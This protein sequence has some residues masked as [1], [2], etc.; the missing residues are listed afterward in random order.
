MLIQIT[1]LLIFKWGGYF[2][3][4]RIQR[5]TAINITASKKVFI[6]IIIPN[7]MPMPAK[8]KIMPKILKQLHIKYPLFSIICTFNTG[9]EICTGMM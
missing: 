1:V 8:N 4:I 2:H 5:P 6:G 3:L 9:L 7:S